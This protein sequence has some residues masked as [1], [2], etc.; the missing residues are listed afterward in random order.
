MI[1]VGEKTICKEC[2]N[3]FRQPPVNSTIKRKICPRCQKLKDF[4]KKR[5]YNQKL[6]AQSNLFNPGKRS[7]FKP[8]K[9]T[10]KKKS[11]LNGKKTPKDRFYKSAAWKW[12]SRY[13]LIISTIDVTE[14]T[15]QCCTCG[16]WMAV[17][18]RN[19]HVGHY[20]KVFDANSTN[21]ATALV[22]VNT[23]PQC[24]HCNHYRGGVMDEMA[25]YIEKKHGKGTVKQLME[26]KKLPLKLDDA[27]LAEIADTY[28]K[29]FYKELEQR[30]IENPWKK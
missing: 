13:I 25:S 8:G 15:T 28:R 10:P 16:K 29:K 17:N 3:E 20:V 1:Q 14:T 9:Y 5:E 19:C 7:G 26:L 4:E 27:Y 6:L 30:G 21:Y 23:G 18:S 22:E 24:D 11:G 2:G 12:F